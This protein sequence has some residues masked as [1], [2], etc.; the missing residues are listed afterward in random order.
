M[1]RLISLLALCLPL[2][3]EA[4]CP[5]SPAGTYSGYTTE[6]R[7][8]GSVTNILSTTVIRSNGTGTATIRGVVRSGESGYEL[9][10]SGAEFL[11]TYSYSSSTCSGT[12][13]YTSGPFQGQKAVLTVGDSG[14]TVYTVFGASETEGAGFRSA[15]GV[16]TKQ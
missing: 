3:A 13:T 14:K 4:A 6:T 11:F 2:A 10:E 16:S 1:L 12:L 5:R 7:G 8:D 15:I 9:E